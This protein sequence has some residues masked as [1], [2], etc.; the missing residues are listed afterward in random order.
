M[1][2]L[3]VQDLTAEEKLRL[4]C[5]EGFWHTVSL[6]GKLPQ[7]C[8]SDGPVGLRKE[9]VA[10]GKTETVPATAYP[11]IHCLANSWNR[12]CARAMGDALAD[13]CI[14]NDVDILLAPG[15]NIKRN[16]LNGRNFEYFSE[17]P[18]LAGT[19]AYEYIDGLQSRG[20]GACVKHFYANNLEYNRMEQSSEVDERTLREIYL[21]PFEWAS[22]AK[23]V[24]AMCAYNR[25]NGV[26]ASENKKGFSILRDEFGFD[27]AIYSDWEAVHDRAAS[28]RA[29]LDIEFPFNQKNYE[30]L[31]ADYRDGKLSDADLDACAARVL[32]LVYRVVK[33]RGERKPRLTAAQRHEVARSVAAEGIVLLKNDGVLPLR[34]G[35]SVAMLGEFAAPCRA[36]MIAGGGS[37]MVRWR[38]P[39][40][41]LSDLLAERLGAPVSYDPSFWPRGIASNIQKPH[42]ALQSAAQSDVAVVCVGTGAEIE[43][44]GGDRESMRLP[45]VQENM[46]LETARVN[47]NTVVVLFAG[48]AVDMSAWKDSVSAILFAGFCGEGGGEA[49]ADILSGAVNPSGKLSETFANCLEDTPSHGRYNSVFVARY[50][51]GLDVGYRYYDTYGKDVAFPFGHGLSYSR[52][53]YGDL[54][55]AAGEGLDLT[56]TLKNASDR[57]GKEVSQVYIRPLSSFVYRPEKELKGYEKTFVAAGK[58]A[59]VSVHLDRDAFGYWSTAKDCFTVDDGIYDV[60]VCAS[61]RDVRLCARVKIEGGKIAACAARLRAAVS[62]REAL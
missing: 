14:E 53:E 21:K 61:S 8:V 45:A 28:A 57:D 24:S 7:V 33:M 40:F 6:N 44:E 62:K 19:L 26:Y 5:S 15:V 9:I 10:D 2:E 37:A 35:T 22:K 58:T 46:I 3:T 17:D 20:V 23:P 29:G 48:S 54:R 51:E 16:P 41:R 56:F 60:L 39:L 32:R 1:K 36:A 50:E 42:L 49:V 27:G 47:P 38:A 52:F 30:R 18:Y 59:R 11:A 4:I 25:I 13:D 31:V 43:Y 34:R 12:A 55:L